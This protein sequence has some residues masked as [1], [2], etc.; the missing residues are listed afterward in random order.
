MKTMVYKASAM[1]AIGVMM[2]GMTACSSDDEP[3]PPAAEPIS[4]SRTETEMMQSQADFAISLL[5]TFSAENPTGNVGISPFSIQQVLSA[6]GNGVSDEG[7]AR[8]AQA[9]GLTDISDLNALNLRLNEALPVRDPKNV[10]ISIANGLWM[11][12]DYTFNPDFVSVMQDNYKSETATYDFGSVNIADVANEWIA[13]KTHDGIKNLVPSVYNRNPDAV[14][15]LANALYFNGKWTTKFEAKDTK[16]GKFTD[17][18]GNNAREVPMMQNSQEIGYIGYENYSMST[19]SFGQG[20]YQML[21]IL[22]DLGTTPQEVLAGLTDASL[23]EGL[24]KMNFVTSKIYLPKFEMSAQGE[25]TRNIASVGL[26]L[27]EFSYANI[28]AN[29]GVVNTYH[30]FSIRV[31]EEGAEIKAATATGGDMSPGFTPGPELRVD[32]PFIFAVYETSSKAILGLGIINDPA[33]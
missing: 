1:L 24:S 12:E 23:K 25:I 30:G 18:Y 10:S 22:P 27:N 11:N 3:T 33:L 19:L 20:M 16:P 28:C 9:L 8:Y 7:R 31:D 21:I 14:F 5:K 17:S 29:A 6:L 2:A 32:R 26:P 4:L 13:K 15:I